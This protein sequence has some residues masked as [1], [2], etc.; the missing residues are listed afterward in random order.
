MSGL[1]QQSGG[2]C[3]TRPKM[4]ESQIES[5]L[6]A[7]VEQRGGEIR[8]CKWIGRPSAPD[9]RVMLPGNCMWIECKA[10][11]EKPTAAQAR[12]HARMRKA[13]ERVEVVDS[14]ER[15]DQLLGRVT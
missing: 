3:T 4:R 9:R 11:G 10:P 1:T 2:L 14:F 12:E 5:Y 7:Q 15:V 6:V 13:G 8:K